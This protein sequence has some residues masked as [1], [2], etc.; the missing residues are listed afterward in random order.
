MTDRDIEH[1]AFTFAL[2][3]IRLCRTLADDRTGRI[4]MNQLLRS[5]TS[6]GANIAEAQGAQS[7]PDF[8]SKM[9]IA[10]KEARETLYWLRLITES[11]LQPPDKMT[12]LIEEADAIVRIVAAIVISAKKNR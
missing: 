5:G 9:S 11:N 4:L 12:P 8:I 2:R 10:Q 6:I 3:I 1:R 7:K